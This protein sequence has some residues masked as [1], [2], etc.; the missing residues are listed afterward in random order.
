MDEPST[1]LDPASRKNLWNVIKCALQDRAMIL[2][3]TLSLPT[4][5]VELAKMRCNKHYKLSALSCSSY[6]CVLPLGPLH[7]I[8]ILIAQLDA[9]NYIMVLFF[10]V[11]AHSMQEAEVLCDRVGIFVDGSLQ[12]LGNPK[13][14]N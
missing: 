1:G 12:C 9:V 10:Y 3:S 11:S 4:L 14:V 2:A 7:L 6:C 13:E 5:L 8:S